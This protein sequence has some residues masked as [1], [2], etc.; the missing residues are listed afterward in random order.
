MRLSFPNNSRS[1][2]E[3]RNCVCFWGYDSTIEISF[4]VEVDALKQLCPNM[5][6]AE[7]GFL[8]AF[9]AALERIHKVANNVYVHGG[10]G[11][12]TYAYSLAADDF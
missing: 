4:F 6:S 3:S 9:D 12:G 2:D 11:K 5:E 7:P 10:S 1:Y 8:K